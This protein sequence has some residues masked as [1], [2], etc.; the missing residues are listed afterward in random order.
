MRL[1]LLCLVFTIQ[2]NWRYYGSWLQN[3][4]DQDYISVLEQLI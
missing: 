1:K 2:K 4:H 3:Q